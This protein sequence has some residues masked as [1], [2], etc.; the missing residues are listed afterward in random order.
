MTEGRGDAKKLFLRSKKMFHTDNLCVLM[1]C[2]GLPK[3]GGQVTQE[4]STIPNQR[5]SPARHLVPLPKMCS[6]IEEVCHRHGNFVA[7]G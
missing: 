6:C 7:I 4:L 2:E 1:P 3:F 5:C